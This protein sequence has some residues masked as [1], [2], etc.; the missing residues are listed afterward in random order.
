MKKTTVKSSANIAFVKYWGRKNDELVLPLNSSISMNL[1]SCFTKTTLEFGDFEKDIV[2]V[3][4]FQSDYK[5]LKNKQLDRVLNQVNRIKNRYKIKN[6]VKIYSENNFP[7]DCGIASSASAFSALT[8][9][10]YEALEIKINN[11]KLSIETRLSGSGSASRS[12][13]DGFVKWHKGSSNESSY[14]TSIFP[15]D[16]WELYDLILVVDIC[17]KSVGSYEGHQRVSDNEYMKAR[18]SNIDKR[19]KQVE[20][21]IEKKNINKLGEAIEADAISLHTVAMNSK[22]PIFYLNSKTWDLIDEIKNLRQQGLVGYF[23]MDAGPNVHLICEKKYKN[24]FLEIFNN[25]SGVQF[26]IENKVSNG[27]EIVNNHLF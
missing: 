1:D 20:E 21:A 24:Q 27:A 9:A 25:F 2:K 14:S 15:T 5:I 16:H 17:N 12:I 13:P 6:K 3:N 22:P 4:F 18:L 11:E 23:T 26:V 10:I 8:K 7:G 19:I